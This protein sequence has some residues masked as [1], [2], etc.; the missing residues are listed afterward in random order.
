MLVRKVRNKAAGT[1]GDCTLEYERINGRYV[2]LDSSEAPRTSQRV[3]PSP[4]QRG[5]SWGGPGGNSYGPGAPRTPLQQQLDAHSSVGPG[6]PS[7]SSNGGMR[8]FSGLWM[9]N[10]GT[11]N[12]D[13][14][15]DD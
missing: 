8:K 2:D 1:L 15:S 10:D 3:N 6:G 4:A 5:G 14:P 9:H 7:S 12:S 11:V 13:P